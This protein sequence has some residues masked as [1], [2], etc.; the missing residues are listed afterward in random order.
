MVGALVIWFSDLPDQ[1]TSFLEA[2]GL[3]EYATLMFKAI[4][5]AILSTTCADVC[6]ECGASQI[7]TGV[8]T[9]GNL[10]ILSLCLPLLRELLQDAEVLLEWG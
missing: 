3:G 5:L 1:M 9:A 7:A 8:E 10:A 4:G 2:E 6:R